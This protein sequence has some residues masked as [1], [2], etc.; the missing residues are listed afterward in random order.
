[1]SLARPQPTPIDLPEWYALITDVAARLV[2]QARFGRNVWIY[3]VMIACV[4]AL[5]KG[6]RTEALA[7]LPDILLQ[8]QEENSI[9]LHRADLPKREYVPTWTT[10]TIFDRSAIEHDRATFHFLATS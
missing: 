4:A 1:M 3:S 8:L 6:D 2:G 5:P 9:K 10:R 7:A